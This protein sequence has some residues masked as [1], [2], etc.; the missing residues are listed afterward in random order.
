MAGRV[1]L[2]NIADML[3]HRDL[4]STFLYSKVDFKALAET[5][6]PWPGEV[7]P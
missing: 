4:S 3:G 6:L 1:P 2:K 7:A 5:A